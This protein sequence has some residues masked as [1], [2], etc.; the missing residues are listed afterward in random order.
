MD[1]LRGHA[2]AF[3]ALVQA[4]D[5][6]GKES[7]LS[8]QAQRLADLVRGTTTGSAADLTNL[9]NYLVS[10]ACDQSYLQHV[11]QALDS[12]VA[13][14][15]NQEVGRRPLQ[16]FDL[17]LELYLP[18]QLWDTL[19]N[20]ALPRTTRLSELVSHVLSLGCR[21]PS[22]NTLAKLCVLTSLDDA[23]LVC[24]AEPALQWLWCVRDHVQAGGCQ[25]RPCTRA[26]FVLLA[27][28][29]WPAW[30]ATRRPLPARLQE[31]QA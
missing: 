4:A 16:D 23:S 6:E 29:A 31:R 10:A 18:S 7:L 15:K 30:F 26:A 11:Y 1:L 3:L 24:Q 14:V 12:R 28:P 2:E 21:C 27:E 20:F 9:R 25:G 8:V 22:A 17:N 13:A 19:L 5:F